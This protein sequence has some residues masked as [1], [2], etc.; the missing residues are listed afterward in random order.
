MKKLPLIVLFFTLFACHP[1]QNRTIDINDFRMNTSDGSRLYFDNV[2]KSNYNMEELDQAGI[3]IYTLKNT[4]NKTL[5]TKII[6]NWRMDQAYLQI[7]LNDSSLSS[8]SYFNEEKKVASL[9][10]KDLNFIDQTRSALVVYNLILT[11][12]LIFQD[13]QMNDTLVFDKEG[14]RITCFDYLR[15]TDNR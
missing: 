15:L 8:L 4:S 12:K 9:P 1:D 14:F 10:V 7:Q 5:T 13:S 11:K 6:H 2:R 3:N